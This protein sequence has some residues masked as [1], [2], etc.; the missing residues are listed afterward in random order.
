MIEALDPHVLDLVL[1]P[2]TIVL[3]LRR[4]IKHHKSTGLGAKVHEIIDHTESAIWWPNTNLDS[5]DGASG[6]RFRRAF[7]GEIRLNNDLAPSSRIGNL[8]IEV[9]HFL[10]VCT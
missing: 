9:L 3:R 1:S 4:I 6:P 2:K 7:F 10:F 8:T 5:V